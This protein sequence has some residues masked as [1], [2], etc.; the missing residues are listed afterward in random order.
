MH[1]HMRIP[2]YTADF[3]SGVHTDGKLDEEK[4]ARFVSQIQAC[5]IA[6]HA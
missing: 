2:T 4:L 3:C 6:F 5:K 1:S